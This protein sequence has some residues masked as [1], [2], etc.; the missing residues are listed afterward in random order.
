[1]LLAGLASRNHPVVLAGDLNARPTEGSIA[2]LE[3]NGYAPLD[4]GATFTYPSLSPNRKIDYIM[5]KNLP[6]TES[7]FEV[8]VETMASDHRPLFAETFLGAPADWLAGYG[9]AP[10]IQENFTDSD[11][12]GMDNYSEWL[13]GTNP[14]N[15][16]SFFGFQSS[17]SGSV[18]TGFQLQWNSIADRTYRVE[19]QAY[20]RVYVE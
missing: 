20:Y 7:T 18:P 5:V 11:G 15:T 2:L 13:T 14:T 4:P 8:V 10:T 9:L 16:L 6:I 19:A 12:D 3:S 17:G 1:V